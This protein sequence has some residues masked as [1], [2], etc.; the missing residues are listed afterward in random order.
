MSETPAQ[1]LFGFVLRSNVSFIVATFLLFLVLVWTARR[2]RQRAA[3]IQ[4]EEIADQKI[5]VA[6]SFFFLLVLGAIR[7]LT[8]ERA[9]GRA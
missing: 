6:G 7:I 8:S 3:A 4:A 9:C 5:F 1:F 2:H